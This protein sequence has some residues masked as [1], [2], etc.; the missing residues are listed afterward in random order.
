MKVISLNT[1]LPR[2]VTWHGISVCTGIYKEPVEGCVPV[3]TLNLGGDRSGR[4]YGSWRQAEPREGLGRSVILSFC[5]A[6]DQPP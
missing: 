6:G 5:P 3:R 1:G 4:P 2:E